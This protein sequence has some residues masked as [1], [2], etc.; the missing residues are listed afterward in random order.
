MTN[1][2]LFEG[3]DLEEV[4]TEAQLCFGPDVEIVAANRVRKGGVMGFFAREWYEVWAHGAPP[5]TPTNAALALIERE[6]NATP[7]T[8]AAMNVDGDSF[9]SMVANA[10]AE[11]APPDRFESA[12]NQFFG[13]SDQGESGAAGRGGRTATVAD[14]TATR[15]RRPVSSSVATLP[16]PTDADVQAAVAMRVETPAAVALEDAPR[17]ASVFDEAPKPRRDVLW[18]MLDRIEE[19][20]TTAAMPDTG[21][22]VFVGD[23]AAALPAVQELGRRLGT[24]STEV[25]VVTRRAVDAVPA[26]LMIEDMTDLASR[27]SRWSRRPGVVPV[28]VDQPLDAANIDQVL[29]ALEVLEPSQVRIVTEAWRLPEQVGRLAGRLGG[30]D[31]LEL[32]EIG[33]AMDPLSMIDLDIAIG[34]IDGRPASCELLAA[35]WLEKRRDD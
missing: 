12:M 27:A 22:V 34:S 5:V 33:D 3:S 9:Q 29:E 4:L 21:L 14:A 2:L 23:A 32:V 18:M 26:W 7:A 8:A 10:L 24:W 28:I 16:N 19:A 15:V 1:S 31:A 30:V 35:V 17:G 25:A 6:A 20:T 13:G 11:Q